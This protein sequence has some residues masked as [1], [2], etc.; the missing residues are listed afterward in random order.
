MYYLLKEEQVSD[1][2]ERT[3]GV[4]ARDDIDEIFAN[5]GYS[6]IVVKTIMQDKKTK[7][8]A[9]KL[10]THKAVYNEW[11]KKTSALKSGDT[12]LIQFPIFEHSLFLSR[13]FKKLAKRNVKVILLIHDLE[14]LREA[15]RKNFKLKHRIRLNIE[16]KNVLKSASWII[17]HN[18]KMKEYIANLNVDR[19]KLVSLE[20]FDYLIKDY[21]EKRLAERSL[22]R[23]EPVI[24]AGNLR[25][26][27][28]GYVYD[29]PYNTSFNL[30]GIEYEGRVGDGVNYFGSFS[31][32]ELPYVLNGSFGLVW[33]GASSETCS[34]VYGEYLRINNPHK[35]SLYLASGIPVVIWK[36]AALAEFVTKNACGIAVDS[37]SDIRGLK[38]K[39][40]DEEYKEMKENAEK[41]S[42][43]LRKGY[44]TL[45][46]VNACCDN[47]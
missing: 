4:K 14:I 36:Q 43:R 13:L 45:K 30:Y 29:L 24:I 35:T 33:D 28:A 16:E 37:L 8:I 23:T 31:P 10:K 38:D 3:A 22:D 44:Y 40:T 2:A 25:K 15:K 42:E 47:A 21:D 19:K 17:V 34:G 39:I 32:D 27:K 26:H 12:L 20:I 6:E 1:K 7:S 5:E 46:A 41:L 18:D 11:S 9:E